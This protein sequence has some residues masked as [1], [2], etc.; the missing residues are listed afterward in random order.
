[1]LLVFS[2]AEIRGLFFMSCARAHVLHL[3]PA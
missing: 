1:M 2:L 3:A